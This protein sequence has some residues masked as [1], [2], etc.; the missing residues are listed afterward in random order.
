MARE[1]RKPGSLKGMI[2]MAADFD[3]LP[4][5][6]IDTMEG[7]DAAASED[8]SGSILVIPSQKPQD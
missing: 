6:I 1:F 4:E 7:D 5:D 3:S 8:V 2:W